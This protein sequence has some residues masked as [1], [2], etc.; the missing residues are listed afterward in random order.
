MEKSVQRMKQISEG[1]EFI[2]TDYP[3]KNSRKNDRE[4]DGRK[5]LI[6]YNKRSLISEEQF[7]RGKSTKD[8][9]RK[10]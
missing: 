9:I 3:A 7:N 10:D 4:I 6:L 1:I 8:T 2:Q 5:M